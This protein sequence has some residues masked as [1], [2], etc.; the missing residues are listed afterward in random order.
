MEN[1]KTVNFVLNSIEKEKLPERLI[2]QFVFHKWLLPF[3]LKKF[4]N[5]YKSLAYMQ[6]L[7]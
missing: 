3:D 5:L 6:E 4:M 1:F 7:M 2:V